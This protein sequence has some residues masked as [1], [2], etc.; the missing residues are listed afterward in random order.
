MASA[1]TDKSERLKKLEQKVADN[2][3]SPL[4]RVRLGTALLGV[5]ASKR[6]EAELKKAL[7]L[8]PECVPALV[9]LGGLYLNRWDFKGCVEVNRRAAFEIPG[10][11]TSVQE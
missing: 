6:A 11:R 1:A 4:H 7:E 10:A 8:D 2:P 5:G 9:N 3:K